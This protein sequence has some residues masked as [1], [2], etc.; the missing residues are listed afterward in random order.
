MVTTLNKIR[1]A[2]PCADGWQKLLVGLLKTKADDESL[3]LIQILDINGIED[4]I[5]ALRAIDDC[6]QIRL[7]A[8]ACARQALPIWDAEYPNDRR[9]LTAIET[10]ERFARGKATSDELAAAWAA[11]GAAAGAAARAAAWDA[12]G[13]AA[14]AAARAAAWDAA[15]DAAWDKQAELFRQFFGRTPHD[16]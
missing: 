11:A 2:S 6:P 7:F 4:A 8:A 12:A 5:W 16:A 9:P 10:A 1:A 14:W 15:G 13:A 3:T